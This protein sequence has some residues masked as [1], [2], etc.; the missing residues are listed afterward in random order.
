LDQRQE[1]PKLELPHHALAAEGTSFVVFD[2]G[3]LEAAHLLVKRVEELLPRRRPRERRPVE[4]GPA[5]PTKIEQS[6]WGSVEGNPHAI[7]HVD[8]TRRSVGH[9]FDRRLVRQEVTAVHGLLEVHLRGVAFALRVH[10]GVDSPLSAD[11]VRSLH[12]H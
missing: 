2:R 6:L 5:E 4:E 9:P 11:R 7:E 1:V 10:A 8:N 3:H 12:R